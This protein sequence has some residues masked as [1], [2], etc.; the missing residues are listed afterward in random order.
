M[1]RKVVVL[2]R[3]G[4]TDQQFAS[5]HVSAPTFSV[6][7]FQK[8]I[9]RNKEHLHKLFARFFW[10]NKEE[11][12]SRHWSSWK[13]LCLPNE[14]GVLGFRSL[15]DVSALF[16]KLWWIF[17]KTK[18]LWSN[19]TWNKYCKKEIP[20][21]VQFR[22][23]SHIWRQMLNVRQDMD[24]EIWWEMKC[25]TTNIWHENWTGLGALYHVVPPNFH[26]NEDLQEVA[27]LRQ[28]DDWNVQLLE[29]SFPEDI[30]EHIIQQVQFEDTGGYWDKPW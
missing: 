30:A 9:G 23:G 29:Q 28:R 20:T 2:W 8:H 22:Q 11:G 27:Y 24:H 14:E 4:Y 5:K 17:R 18:S 15:F 3:Q 12:R 21:V 25:G 7:S 16:S 26:S 13:K 19:F 1:E 6:G 10:S